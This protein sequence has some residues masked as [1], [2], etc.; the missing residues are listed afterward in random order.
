M[1]LVKNVERKVRQ[2]EGFDVIVRG[3]DGHDVRADRRGIPQYSYTRRAKDDMTVQAWKHQRFWPSY[4]GFLVD[5]L[6]YAGQPVAGN[7]KLRTVRFDY[8]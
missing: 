5:V 7:T 4:P 1:P 8:P 6:D 2:V 3:E